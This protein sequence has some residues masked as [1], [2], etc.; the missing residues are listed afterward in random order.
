MSR[1]NLLR[2][3][4]HGEEPQEGP[5]EDRVFYDGLFSLFS[6]EPTHRVSGIRYGNG[7]QGGI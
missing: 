5:C 6:H 1:K 4:L 2:L 3:D 7:Q